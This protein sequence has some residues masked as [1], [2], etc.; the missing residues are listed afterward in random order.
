MLLLTRVTKE[1][2]SADA[3]AGSLVSVTAMDHCW[4]RPCEFWEGGEKVSFDSCAIT[5][6]FLP[7]SFLNESKTI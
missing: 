4:R 2:I 6:M 5:L 7:C 3:S 1:K